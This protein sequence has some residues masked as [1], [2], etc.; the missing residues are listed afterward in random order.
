MRIW[1][2]FHKKS[3]IL[4]SECRSRSSG[5]FRFK[6]CFNSA[7]SPSIL[8]LGYKPGLLHTLSTFLRSVDLWKRRKLGT[9]QQILK[10]VRVISILVSTSYNNSRIYDEKSVLKASKKASYHV[11]KIRFSERNNIIVFFMKSYNNYI[12]FVL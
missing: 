2:Y 7:F 5:C 11:I 1:Y 10:L 3:K 8:Y 9:F 12:F 4:P 6:N